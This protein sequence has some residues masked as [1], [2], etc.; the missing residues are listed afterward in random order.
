[1]EVEA[2][3][4]QGQFTACLVHLGQFVYT[5]HQGKVVGLLLYPA[6]LLWSWNDSENKIGIIYKNIDLKRVFLHR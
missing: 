4:V 2:Q 3:F 5:H 6:D 1:M